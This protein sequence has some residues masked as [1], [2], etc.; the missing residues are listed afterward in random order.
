MITIN[1]EKAKEITKK[2]GA[3]ENLYFK[4]KVFGFKPLESFFKLQIISFRKTKTKDLQMMSIRWLLKL[5][6][7]KTS[8]VK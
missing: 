3:T 1:I 7:I 2:I 6:K 5:V 8:H 4:Q